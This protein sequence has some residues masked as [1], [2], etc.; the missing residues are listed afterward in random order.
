MLWIAGDDEL[1][2]RYNPD[3]AQGIH[4]CLWILGTTR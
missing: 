3:P 2:N 4:Q 1:V